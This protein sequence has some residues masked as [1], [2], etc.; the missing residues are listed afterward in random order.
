MSPSWTTQDPGFL[1]DYQFALLSAP[2]FNI[3]TYLD[4]VKSK[5]KLT[6]IHGIVNPVDI[7]LPANLK[8]GEYFSL[9]ASVSKPGEFEV[10]PHPTQAHTLNIKPLK[11]SA[12][13]L[14]TLVAGSERV[15]LELETLANIPSETQYLSALKDKQTLSLI[16]G[17]VNTLDLTAAENLTPGDVYSLLTRVSKAGEFEVK[18]HPTQAG[19]ITIKPLRSGARANLTLIAGKQRVELNLETIDSGKVALGDNLTL[20]FPDNLTLKKDEIREISVEGIAQG[21]FIFIGYKNSNP[22]GFRVETPKDKPNVVRVTALQDEA[23]ADVTVLIGQTT[24]TLT[25]TSINVLQETA[26][27]LISI[28]SPATGTA[29]NHTDDIKLVA[30]IQNPAV[31]TCTTVFQDETGNLLKTSEVP[32]ETTATQVTH[33]WKATD[34]DNVLEKVSLKAVYTC[35][36]PP[37]EVKSNFTEVKFNSLVKPSPQPQS[38]TIKA[39]PVSGQEFTQILLEF[40]PLPGISDY[41]VYADGRLLGAAKALPTGLVATFKAE[42][43]SAGTNYVFKVD[44]LFAD[45]VTTSGEI[46]ASTWTPTASSNGAVFLPLPAA[47]PMPIPTPTPIPGPMINNLSVAN[48]CPGTAIQI[49]GTGFSA[50]PASNTVKFDATVATVTAASTTQLTVTV[51]TGNNGTRA[52]NVTVGGNNSNTQNFTIN[53]NILYVD[54]G[55]GGANNGTSWTNAYTSLTAALTASSGACGDSLWVKAGTYKPGAARTNTFQLKTNVFVYGGFAGTETDLTQRN[56][57]NNQTTLSADI[58]ADD[59]YGTTPPGNIAD[60][61]YHVVSAVSNSLLDGFIVIGGNADGGAPNNTG[62]GIKAPVPGA[63]ITLRNLV[64]E[65]NTALS[66]GGIGSSSGFQGLLENSV[67]YRNVATTS[68][69]GAVSIGAGTST[70][71]NVLIAE[72][73]APNSRQMSTNATSTW[74]NVTLVNNVSNAGVDGKTLIVNGGSLVINNSVI[75]GNTTG[76]GCNGIRNGNVANTLNILNSVVDNFPTNSCSVSSSANIQTTHPSFLNAGLAK[77]ADGKF[78]TVDD[79]YAL[80]AGSTSALDNGDNSLIPG[81]ILFDITGS[82]NRIVNTTVDRGAYEKP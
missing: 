17:M 26:E 80:T 19:Q 2:H 36:A 72:N 16:N 46:K 55:A 51:P 76:L 54:A 73:Q 65:S 34:R 12:S 21:Q 71:N 31:G 82:T 24:R 70:F 14:L 49:N 39:T 60:N 43:L 79:G 64:I 50:T 69:G 78:F 45:K 47:T 41:K 59:T 32:A 75:W 1:S 4:S 40:V 10:R 5:G 77:G 52:V 42:G 18:P 35:S 57:V 20:V 15:V 62:G 9:L 58:N 23:T 44:A 22:Q 53:G 33:L 7:T 74:N 67:L 48:A 66:G 37:K 13:A 27:P 11:P 29:F 25:F 56:W 30:Q 81:G 68:I 8:K 38:L 28:N 3:Q 61:N 6:L 63:N